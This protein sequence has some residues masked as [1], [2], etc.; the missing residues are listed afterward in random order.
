MKIGYVV[1]ASSLLVSTVAGAQSWTKYGNTTYGSNG[2]SYS[3]YGNTTYGSNGSS[4]T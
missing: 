2:N 3:T 4:L 1:L